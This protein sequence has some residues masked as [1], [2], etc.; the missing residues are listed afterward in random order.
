MDELI[1]LGLIGR[2]LTR[3][4]SD[5]VT[6]YNQAL[7]RAGIE[8]TALKEFDVDGGGWSPQIATEKGKPFYL[9]LGNADQYCVIVSPEQIGQPLYLPFSSYLRR[10]M[11]L[12]GDRFRREI[13]DITRTHSILLRLDCGIVRCKTPH[14][15]RKIEKITVTADIGDLATTA[16]K[17]KAVVDEIMSKSDAW[18]RPEMRA[19]LIA[20]SQYGDLRTRK[21]S[22]TDVEFTDVDSF[23]TEA[24]GGIYLLRY[25][26]KKTAPPVTRIIACSE[27]VFNEL[28]QDSQGIVIDH[29]GEPDL[30][31]GLIKSK[32]LKVDLRERREAGIKDLIESLTLQF[33]IE[34]EPKT[35]YED[36]TVARIKQAKSKLSDERLNLLEMLERVQRWL[37][38][39]THEIPQLSRDASNILAESGKW[40]KECEETIGLLLARVRPH[41]I[42][43]LYRMD[44]TGFTRAF[45]TWSS[46]RQAHAV[47]LVK[48]CC[49]LPEKQRVSA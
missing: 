19:K 18:F 31:A 45:R 27:K 34:A 2:G 39:P 41:A 44:K 37:E 25:K 15:L 5:L 12:Y 3:V 17:Q 46:S 40:G 32:W 9:T 33:V 10:I 36:L 49:L 47:A 30:I 8:P 6:R 4:G 35:S 38:H 42:L 43:E 21:L 20:S 24:F 26:E 28:Q 23:Y 13:A 14:D 1:A 16:E 29:T 11:D 48:K 7:E 22:L